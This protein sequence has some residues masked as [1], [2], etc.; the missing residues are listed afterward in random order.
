MTILIL[1]G[2]DDAHSCHMLDH[3]RSLG[4]DVELF[5]SRWFPAHLRISYDPAT[6]KGSLTFPTGRILAFDEVSSVYW[7]CYNQFESPGLPDPEQAYIASNDTRGM[8]ESVLMRLKARWVNGWKAC[9]LH[10][11]KPVQLAMVAATGFPIPPTLLGNDPGEIKSFF[12]H[13]PNSI[14]KPVQGG[15]H[16]SFLTEAHLS[17]DNLKNL[18]ISPVTIQAKI[19]GTDIRV[20]VAG[21]RVHACSI[22][23][24]AVDFR[25]DPAALIKPHA[26]P[27]ELEEKT[28][29]IARTL[30]LVWTGIDLK[31]TAD[32]QYVF[33]EANPSPMFMGFESRSGLPL[34]NALTSLLV[35]KG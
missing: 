30:D 11:T 32:G 4:E 18:A 31:L 15:A 16:T 20:F 25:D 5:D 8:F 3:L 21:E 9:N 24:D 23:T 17:D 1:G 29:R 35:Q 14:F 6:D 7:R 2:M 10:Q 27:V 22:H 28:I 13:Y 19:D 34:T 26:L 33:L 12:S